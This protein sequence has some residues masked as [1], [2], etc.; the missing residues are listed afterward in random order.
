[1]L[2]KSGI[3]ITVLM[4]G[5]AIG[6]AFLVG[7]SV[8]VGSLSK[9]SAQIGSLSSWVAALAT[10]SIAILTVFLAKETWALRQF[11]LQHTELIRKAG[12]KPTV[13]VH[14]QS[15]PAAFHF[16]DIHIVNNGP[17]TALNIRFS[18]ENMNPNGIGVYHEVEAKMMDLAILKD[19]ISSLGP[20]QRRSSFLV[21]ILELNKSLGEGT[22]DYHSKVLATFEDVEG[23][24]YTSTAHFNFNELKG[25]S[26][27]GG[28]D[29]L[30]RISKSLDAIQTDLRSFGTG[31]RKLQ[32][33]I[34]TSEDRERAKEQWEKERAD[35]A[36]N[37]KE[38]P[39]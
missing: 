21:S 15:S 1:M 6:V 23:T 14:L 3:A 35:A 12:I 29:P 8:G 2:N 13:D 7:V 27:I 9:S 31:F 24:I 28:G 30:H 38:R 34:Y 11:Q 20:G 22:F 16:F 5:I 36:T 19:G 17:G 25:V 18:V 26:E 39:N 10:V 32:T 4:I 37:A 33:D